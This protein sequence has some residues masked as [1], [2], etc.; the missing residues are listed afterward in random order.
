M[1]A[2]DEFSWHM[3]NVDGVLSVISLPGTAKTVNAGWNEGS[4]KWQVLPRN[5]FN[6]V[7]ATS[8][9]PTS[10]RLFNTDCS[11]IPIMVFTADH[12]AETIE[13]VVPKSNAIGLN[14]RWIGSPFA[15]PPE[16]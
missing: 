11:V 7:Q 16:T 1:A 2:I 14:T 5:S 15:W 3:E 6:L 13:R 12:K 9:I 8:Y 10:N 4:L